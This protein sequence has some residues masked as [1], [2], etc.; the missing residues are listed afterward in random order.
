VVPAG[1]VDGQALMR[2]VCGLPLL[3]LLLTACGREPAGKPVAADGDSATMAGDTNGGPSITATR[4]GLPKNDT[5]DLDR[6]IALG[7]IRVLV[8]LSRTNFYI[9]RGTQRGITHDRFA[10]FEKELNATLQKKGGKRVDIVFVPV[11]RDEL[12]PALI[13]G[14]GDIAAANLSVTETRLEEVD[15]SSPLRTGVSEVLVTAP[16]SPPVRSLAD[17]AG[18]EVFIRES[19]SFFGSVRR[20]NDSLRK[21]GVKPIKVRKADERLEDEDVLEMVNAGLVPATIVDNH[22]AE[23]WGEVR[24]HGGAPHRHVRDRRGD[25]L[26]LPQGEPGAQGHARC[27]RG[28]ACQGH[29]ARQHPRP[30]VLAGRRV[31]LQ[32]GHEAEPGPVSLHGGALPQVWTEVWL[33]SPAARR[34]GLPGIRARPGEAKPRR[35]RRCHAGD[36]AHRLRCECGAKLRAGATDLGLDPNVWFNNVEVVAARDIGRETVTYVRNIYKYY[37]AYVLATEQEA[38][39]QHAVDQAERKRK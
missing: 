34:A 9:D 21:A 5:G 13:D 33:Q 27:V 30:A 24:Q 25:R 11:V 26:G 3:L 38:A 31:R 17:M 37:V 2:S 14:R 6:M 18:R 10:K 1:G 32:C 19:S 22:V 4:S 23:F 28:N 20:V 12:V 16:S 39:R 29:D 8:T 7:R 36:A 35:G 15:F